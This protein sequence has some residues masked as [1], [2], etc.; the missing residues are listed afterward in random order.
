MPHSLSSIDQTFGVADTC[1]PLMGMCFQLAEN[2]GCQNALSARKEFLSTSRDMLSLAEKWQYSVEVVEKVHFLSSVHGNKSVSQA[3]SLIHL[4]SYSSTS[5]F[6]PITHKN[7]CCPRAYL[8]NLWTPV[9]AI[10]NWLATPFAAACRLSASPI[11]GNSP[12]PP[13]F[14]VTRID[15]GGPLIDRLWMTIIL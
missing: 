3:F 9:T 6:A 8:P 15:T 14:R 5:D 1:F 4:H 2:A 11:S 10:P 12:L 7:H 13:A